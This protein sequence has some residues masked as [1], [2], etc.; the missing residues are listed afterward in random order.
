MR[1][2]LEQLEPG[3]TIRQSRGNSYLTLRWKQRYQSDSREAL[4][5]HI[6][7][8]PADRFQIIDRYPERAS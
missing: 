4:E 3:P 7:A 1:F 6:A 5:A 8:H 2:I